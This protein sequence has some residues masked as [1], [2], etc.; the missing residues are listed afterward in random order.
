ME[1]ESTHA[2]G[3]LDPCFDRTSP[4]NNVEHEGQ[5]ARSTAILDGVHLLSVSD[6]S[7]FLQRPQET[8][9]RGDRRVKLS[10]QHALVA[11]CWRLFG[12]IWPNGTL[13]QIVVDSHSHRKEMLLVHATILYCSDQ[14]T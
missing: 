3:R 1:I 12:I 11:L 6:V 4:K 13:Q 7:P 8:G 2:F 9:S 5:I 14:K 10:A